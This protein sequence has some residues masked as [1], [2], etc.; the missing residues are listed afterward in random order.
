MPKVNVNV[1]TRE[2]LVEKAGLRPAIADAILEYR[3]RH[4][5]RITDVEALDELPGV[6]PATLDELRSALDFRDKGEKAGNGNGSD[7]AP[8]EGEKAA[9][10]AVF[11][12]R[13]GV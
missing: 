11:A 2:D 6:G 8:R 1:A 4:G 13:S 3:G 7:K 9:A 12:A 5:G 10:G